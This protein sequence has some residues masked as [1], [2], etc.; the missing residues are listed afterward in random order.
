MGAAGRFFAAATFALVNCACAGEPVKAS[1]FGFDPADST[2]CLQAAFDSGAREII[3]DRQCGD[4]ISG[5][6]YIRS[7]QRV[8]LDEG[9]TV[10]AKEGAY[11]DRYA[12]LFNISNAVDVVLRGRKGSRLA[13][14][15]AEYMDGSRCR[16]GEWR[17]ALNLRG[18][19]RVLIESMRLASS[20]GDGI[21]VLN[22]ED[23]VIDRAVCEDNLRQGI[24]VIG[25]E[26]L[27]VKNSVF[28]TTWGAAPQCGLDIEPNGASQRL[29]DIVFED[30]V[31]EKNRSAGIDLHLANQRSRSAEMSITFRRCISRDNSGDGFTSFIGRGDPPKGTIIFEDCRAFANGGPAL[32]V[33]NM[34]ELGPVMVFRNCEF[35]SRGSGRPAVQMNVSDILDDFCNLR[36][37]DCR[38]FTDAGIDAVVFPSLSGAGMGKGVEGRIDAV[39][40]NA[41]KTIDMAEFALRHPPNREI[42]DFKTRHFEYRD[43]VPNGKALD[44]TPAGN[45]W[46]RGDVTFIQHIPGAGEWP[47]EI[48][49]LRLTRDRKPL[50]IKLRDRQSTDLGDLLIG[51]DSTNY[52]IRTRG[53]GIIRFEAEAGRDAVSFRSRWPG[54][55]YLVNRLTRVY[56][57][58]GARFEFFQPSS[59]GE[60]VVDITP[61]EAVEVRLLDPA[62]S[63]AA[64][65]GKGIFKEL[66]KAKAERGTWTAIV[67]RAREDFM[68]RI[69][70]PALPIVSVRPG[71]GFSLSK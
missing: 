16:P 61:E 29:V 20:G 13:M 68:M 46:L 8:T 30:C 50:R 43:L 27:L 25:A 59:T 62:G 4:W 34:F 17:H 1:S 55:G 69:G 28:R 3:V 60:T 41:K 7:N 63:V 36:F 38:A 23:V 54:Q 49:V 2:R 33:R 47:V 45:V 67:P 15:K 51:S 53:E 57:A 6:V 64:G 14:N 71:M 10:R 18:A 42:I 31:F 35:D 56:K 11:A 37:E 65:T 66:L 58:G 48:D 22:T 26:R 9:V 52:V 12:S 32:S 21:Y 70:S 39:S 24:S 5:P 19:K 40:G 44:A